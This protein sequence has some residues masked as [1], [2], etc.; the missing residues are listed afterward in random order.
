MNVEYKTY[1]DVQGFEVTDKG[2]DTSF[3]EYRPTVP[4]S[5]WDAGAFEMHFFYN[6]WR[7]KESDVYELY[8]EINEGGRI[9]WIFPLSVYSSSMDDVDKRQTI[10]QYLY[11][12]YVRLLQNIP[13]LKTQQQDG[14][15]ADYYNEDVI[16]MVL[17]KDSVYDGF[18]IDDYLPSL[19]L[20][21]YTI[22]SKIEGGIDF[23]YNKPAKISDIEK[24]RGH[25]IAIKKSSDCLCS[26]TY[27]STIFRSEL[28][29]A[30]NALH[31][32]ILL[33]QVMEILMDLA[34]RDNIIDSAQ[35]YKE[36]KLSPNELSERI[37]EAI[38]ERKLIR[39]LFDN[40]SIKKELC[41]QFRDDAL[42][43]FEKIH[44]DVR[45]K[46]LPD[47]LYDL[48]NQIF[49]AYRSFADEKEKLIS[50]LSLSE[51]IFIEV[52]INYGKKKIDNQEGK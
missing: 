45:D 26:N 3:F 7:A 12:A 23:H 44:Y 36:E 50:V 49:H 15:L 48:R 39:K 31:R 38:N 14:V 10:F 19:Y 8:L 30:N 35:L 6:P 29:Y 9:G 17:H 32:F 42:A 28:P 13:E 43:L 22:L 33:Y 51:K 20:E 24:K 46:N 41:T 37:R 47:L 11:A 2:G 18:R 4:E 25:K 1:V 34:S 40:T 27:I 5:L 52:I 16:I 21:G